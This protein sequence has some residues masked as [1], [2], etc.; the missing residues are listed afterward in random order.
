MIEDYSQFMD[1]LKVYVNKKINANTNQI[2][3]T[4][5]ILKNV[6]RGWRGLGTEQMIAYGGVRDRHRFTVGNNNS[7]PPIVSE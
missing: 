2:L 5:D 4:E 6:L 1:K 7:N 3:D